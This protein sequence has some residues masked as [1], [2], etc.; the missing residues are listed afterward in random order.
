[1][2]LFSNRQ[3]RV[4]R[5]FILGV[6]LLG[7]IVVVQAWPVWPSQKVVVA[8]AAPASSSENEPS[9]LIDKAVFMN[10]LPY[11]GSYGSSTLVI[12]ALPQNDF[13]AR[14]EYAKEPAPLARWMT[15]TTTMVLNGGY[16]NEDWSPAGYLV[17]SGERIGQR[18][19]DDNKSGLMVIQDGHISLRD[20]STQPIQKSEHF[21]YAVQ[22]YPWLIRAGQAALHEDSGKMSRRTAIGLDDQY[23]VYVIVA[24]NY[25][26]SLYQLMNELLRSGIAFRD[27]LNLD[28]GPSTGLMVNSGDT[29]VSINS[30][31]PV[32]MVVRFI[33]K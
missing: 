25:D 27:V 6:L 15:A 26:I 4:F 3:G 29:Q 18:K 7:G 1:M 23:N 28:G 2:A 30:Q 14:F 13:L 24:N 17:I 31:S 33:K 20:L 16:F 19:F 11:Y 5:L 21:E 22:S 8:P 32:P 9:A 12:A 10:Y